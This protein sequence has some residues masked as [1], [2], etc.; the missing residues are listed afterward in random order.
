MNKLTRRH[1]ISLL[2]GTAVAMAL[3]GALMAA[4]AT[5]IVVHKTPW[6]GCCTNWSAHLR[7]AGF[8]VTEVK[9]EDLTPIKQQY[10]VPAALEGCHTGVVDGYALEG[11]V[12]AEDIKRLLL[13]RPN[14]KGLAVAGMPMGSPGMEMGPERDAF[15]VM[16]FSAV[17]S[18]IYASYTAL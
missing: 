8:A 3:P 4:P 10:G 18:T 17:G 7:E 5:K 9:H 15:D 11:H 13:E 6:C 1:A 12:P 16:L 2:A 14:A